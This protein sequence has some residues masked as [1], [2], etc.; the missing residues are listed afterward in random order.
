MP[1]FTKPFNI[2]KVVPSPT[3]YLMKILCKTL[4][5]ASLALPP[6]A[7][8]QAETISLEINPAETGEAIHPFI[9]GQFIEHLGRCIYGG[10][11][12]ETLEDRKFYFPITADYAPYARLTDTPFP[13][14][15]ASPW[16]IIG[17]ANA[18]TMITNDPF[19]GDHS[20][21]ILAG[22]GIQ[23]HDLGVIGNLA[24]EGYVW[25]KALDGTAK[26]KVTLSWGDTP[27]AH[28]S[29]V[30]TF[31]GTDYSKQD[32]TL[33][34]L[35]TIERGAT[36]AFEVL[37]GDVVL[38]PPSLMPSN[39]IGGMRADTIALL[40]QL[41]APVYRWP[42]GNFVSGYDWRD[43]IG[44][45][46]RRPPRKNPAWTGVE[47]N[48][49][50]TD[51]FIAFCREIDTAPMIAANTGFGD[52]YSAAQWVEYTN[53]GTETLGGSWRAAN[54]HEDPYNVQDWCV[55]NEMFGRWQ[56]G[57][58]ALSHYTIKHNEV[59]TAMWKVDP[60]L[61]LVG[62]GDLQT[63]NIEDNESNPLHEKG[64]S[65]GMLMRSAD[66]MSMLSEHF[67]SGRTPWSEVGRLPLLEHVRLLKDQIRSKADGHR[68]L[69]ARL[70]NLD[71]RKVTIAMDEWNYWHRDYVYGELGCVYDLSDTL[72][73]AIGLHEF[74]RQSDII[75]M[76]HYAQTV[77]VIGAI[78]TTR[79]EAEME[80]TGLV[81]QLYRTKFGS[82]PLQIA[83]EFGDIDIAAALTADRSA[84]TLGV[85]N[86]TGETVD[87]AL[88]LP[89]GAA[90]TATRWHVA[91]ED[92]FAHN[93][94]GEPRV[95]DIVKTNSISTRAP[96]TVPALSA[97][98]YRIELN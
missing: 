66:Q 26:I 81:L 30:L 9:Y 12:A 74:F 39:N 94:P 5:A 52:A 86:P 54:G 47:H 80:G 70:P 78:K 20:P 29:T 96:V 89:D 50:G 34:P 24:Y 33:T 95:L 3:S 79:T 37:S 6:I 68:E 83:D 98:V 64:W 28:S 27:D 13:V 10:I 76:A 51:E 57:F 38:G 25:A 91:G 43:G 15:G 1:P 67:Y 40:K 73:A 36:I 35:A 17:D 88:S 87:L 31:R 49:F 97:T 2:S 48:D 60:Y 61:T 32:F 23:Q 62:V 42:G 59:A 16:E 8:S 46:D 44:D 90:A 82:I 22:N 75:K 14:V 56:L 65:E 41:D 77:N 63:V 55:G 69:Q 85:V 84:L 4:L 11:W 92:E 45:R 21:R 53:G 93:T 71:G 7:S 72:G 19:V 58:M 18:V